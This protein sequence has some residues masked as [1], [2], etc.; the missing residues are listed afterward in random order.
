[1]LDQHA[2]QL[3]A[4]P[5]RAPVTIGWIV[6]CYPVDGALAGDLRQLTGLEVSFAVERGGQWNLVA[7]TLATAT[8]AALV[9]QLPPYVEALDTRLLQTL[10]GEQ[11]VRF[12]SRVKAPVSILSPCCS[13]RLPMR[14]RVSRPCA[15]R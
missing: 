12:V 5:V 15:P 3:I 1:M 6:D 8:A 4:V 10:Q 2:F 14:W 13:G 11:Q 9:E 7:T